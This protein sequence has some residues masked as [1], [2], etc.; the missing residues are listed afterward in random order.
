MQA[1]S[2]AN[3]QFIMILSHPCHHDNAVHHVAN[4]D[5]L[6]WNFYT[7]DLESS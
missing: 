4:N 1:C 7:I 3:T 2:I 5:E 6:A